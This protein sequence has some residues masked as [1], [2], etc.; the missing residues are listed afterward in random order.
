MNSWLFSIL[1]DWPDITLYII[2]ISVGK[3]YSHVP[4]IFSV[5]FS[6]FFVDCKVFQARRCTPKNSKMKKLFMN[7]NS[8]CCRSLPCSPCRDF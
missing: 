3:L 8:S 7:S 6:S 1:I 4:T 2:F 5:I